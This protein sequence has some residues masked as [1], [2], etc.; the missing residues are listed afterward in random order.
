MKQ[1]WFEKLFIIS[2]DYY[3]FGYLLLLI[4]IETLNKFDVGLAIIK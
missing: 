4:S 3:L 2:I 1:M